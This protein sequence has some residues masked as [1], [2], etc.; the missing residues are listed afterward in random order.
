MATADSEKNPLK[1]L[2]LPFALRTVLAIMLAYSIL[3]RS[4]PGMMSGFSGS[5]PEGLF[6][7]LLL[8][9]LASIDIAIVF[10][11]WLRVPERSLECVAINAAYETKEVEDLMICGTSPNEK[12]L[13][14]IGRWA[15]RAS[16]RF[17]GLPAPYQRLAE[18]AL[19]VIAFGIIAPVL[20]V[21]LQMFGKAGGHPEVASIVWSWVSAG[22]ISVSYL[23]WA[24]ML[25]QFYSASTW[26]STITASKIVR[27]I[28]VMLVTASLIA[29]SS[30]YF[31]IRFSSAPSLQPWSGIVI[32]GS[33]ML[34]AGIGTI[35]MLR[36]REH[37]GT[38]SRTKV[39][40][41]ESAGVHPQ[42]ILNGLKII[43]PHA[44]AG[45]STELG[46][47]DVLF[48]EQKNITG[49]KFEGL[50][51]GEYGIQR[52]KAVH[53]GA[54]RIFALVFAI[55][56]IAIGAIAE[57]VLWKGVRE[58]FFEHCI[59]AVALLLFGNLALLV[60]NFPISEMAWKSCLFGCK[61][62]GTYQGRSL[63]TVAPHGEQSGFGTY[64]T[65]YTLDG[66]F[67]AADSV[68]FFDMSLA[69]SRAR[70]ILVGTQL[71]VAKRD[72]L[73]GALR[74]HLKRVSA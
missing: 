16:D 1:P 73:L 43:L 8:F 72:E 36:S 44:I 7:V 70:R 21:L 68:S 11:T 53:L 28:G 63:S 52:E 61:L 67:A 31:G 42:T 25:K 33:I 56:G 65:E 6:A 37:G 4:A 19:T 27:N 59:T 9:T 54:L 2:S 15:E 46:N 29:F 49:G 35:I 30:T 17:F 14:P 26:S 45:T 60:A 64:V 69:K 18:I 12:F 24:Q 66:S 20:F 13:S 38:M 57:I 55:A 10:H 22:L 34:V 50:A 71:D 74:M 47:W 3:T 62:E 51:L 39:H 5:S 58:A 48:D 23:Y 41:S 40:L 32:A